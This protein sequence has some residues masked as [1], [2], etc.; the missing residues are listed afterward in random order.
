MA[1]RRVLIAAWGA[2]AAALAGCAPAAIPEQQQPAAVSPAGTG[3]AIVTVDVPE[4]M[5]IKPGGATLG[6]DL[7]RTGSVGSGRYFPMTEIETQPV[8][9]G[10]TRHVFRLGES[11]TASLLARRSESAR[12]GPGERAGPDVLVTPRFELCRT[13]PVPDER[14]TIVTSEVVIESLADE[15]VAGPTILT[16]NLVVT[17]GPE[18]SHDLHGIA[19]GRGFEN[20]FPLCADA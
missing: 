13:G 20:S 4:G 10:R 19:R 5:D 12:P 17:S 2:L 6:I 3:A 7:Y 18:R 9:D 1:E 16:T 15:L 8:A 14:P 11:Q